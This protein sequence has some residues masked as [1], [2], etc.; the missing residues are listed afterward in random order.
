MK[1]IVELG[2]VD[3][4]SNQ[5]SFSL[6]DERP[7]TNGMTAYCE[8]TG[9]RLLCYGSLLGGFLSDKW[10][11]ASDPSLNPSLLDTAS[12]KKYYRFISHWGGGGRS[13][14]SLFQELLV[15]CRR[16]ADKHQSAH[17]VAVDGSTS[18]TAGSA[19][20]NTDNNVTIADIAMR[21]T[22]QQPGVG[23]VIVGA[24]LGHS[25]MSHVK[26]NKRVFTFELDTEDFLMLRQIQSRGRTLP[27]DCGDEYRG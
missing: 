4:L 1:E 19:V 22:L 3:V 26:E 2:G 17:M 14:W 6:V 25:M 9:I 13:A 16:I 27:G 7:N 10:L 23:G 12:L 24:R 21:W 20:D 18:S 15:A 8:Q 5:V 11:G